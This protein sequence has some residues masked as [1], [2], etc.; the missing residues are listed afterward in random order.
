MGSKGV[1]MFLLILA[2][3]LFIAWPSLENLY[4]R[5]MLHFDVDIYQDPDEKEKEK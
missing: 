4:Y 2:V 5:L 1:F 3:I